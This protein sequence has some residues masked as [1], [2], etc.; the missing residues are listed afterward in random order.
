MNEQELNIAYYVAIWKYNG[1][2][3]N[4]KQ[5][6]K[7]NELLD[8]EEFLGIVKEF[9]SISEAGTKSGAT[10]SKNVPES[11]ARL[12]DI[13]VTQLRKTINTYLNNK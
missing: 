6:E 3:L 7:I 1:L 13:T 5:L 8:V 11:Y 2:D 10:Y 9:A 12:K 4:P